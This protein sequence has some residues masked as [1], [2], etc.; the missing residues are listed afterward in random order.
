MKKSDELLAQLKVISQQIKEHKNSKISQQ[1]I[2]KL[3]ND[4]VDAMV[5]GE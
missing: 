3:K 2:N 1:E 4:Y 5:R